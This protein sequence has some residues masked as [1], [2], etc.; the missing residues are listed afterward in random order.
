MKKSTCMRDTTHSGRCEGAGWL[1]GCAAMTQQLSP[2]CMEETSVQK[3][4]E[5][6]N[7][8][9]VYQVSDIICL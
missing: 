9:N 6:A 3:L 7:N 8:T 2:T 1:A 5:I 4:L